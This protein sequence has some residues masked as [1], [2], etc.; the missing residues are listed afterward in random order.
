MENVA[1]LVV[2]KMNELDAVKLS[3]SR[4]DAHAAV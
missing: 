4:L 3:D 2:A 1:K